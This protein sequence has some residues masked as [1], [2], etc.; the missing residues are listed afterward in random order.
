LFGGS[1]PGEF[2][3]SY[4]KLMMGMAHL[5]QGFELIYK[6]SAFVDLDCFRNF[7]GQF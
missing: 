6:N 2:E 4:T 1:K 3:P 7:Q 5:T